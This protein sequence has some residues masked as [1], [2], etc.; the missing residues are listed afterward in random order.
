MKKALMLSAMVIVAGATAA[1]AKKIAKSY[2]FSGYCDGISGITVASGVMRAYHAYSSCGSGY[3][4][5]YLGGADLH[6]VYP[7]T[8]TPAALG[9]N[10][11]LVYDADFK[12]LTW[13]LYFMSAAYEIPFEE[14]NAGDLVKGYSAARSGGKTTVHAGLSA[15]HLI[16]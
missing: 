3:P 14:V 8:A 6:N 5:T 2:T 10:Y 13:Q 9:P 4:V 16:K 15:A 12:T 11:T 1:N 7:L